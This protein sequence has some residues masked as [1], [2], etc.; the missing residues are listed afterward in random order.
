MPLLLGI[1]QCC[2]RGQ[3]HV[4]EIWPNSFPISTTKSLTRAREFDDNWLLSFG[5]GRIG[6]RRGDGEMS[7]G[8]PICG[9]WRTPCANAAALHKHLWNELDYELAVAAARPH[10]S[11][12][13]SYAAAWVEGR[14]MTIEQ[15]L[16]RDEAAISER[17][18]STPHRRTIHS[19]NPINQRY[20]AVRGRL[21][22]SRVEEQ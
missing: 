20:P 8:Q 17:G 4:R 3:K 11:E 19:Q 14:S 12:Q 5:L 22:G 2:G 9:A 13:R 21:A 16:I 18:M 15:V 7:P 10:L 6:E 1:R